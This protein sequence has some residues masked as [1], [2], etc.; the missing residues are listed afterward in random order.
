MFQKTHFVPNGDGWHLALK[1]TYD[2][3]KLRPELRPVAIGT[4]VWQPRGR[5]GWER[6]IE[7]AREERFSVAP[8]GRPA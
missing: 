1:Q 3:E 7:E 6:A 4:S 8:S 5:N 2:E